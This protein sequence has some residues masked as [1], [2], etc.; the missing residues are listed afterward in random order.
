MVY[1]HQRDGT[2]INKVVFIVGHVVENAA[3]GPDITLAIVP[4]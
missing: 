2:Y 4:R 3:D 1:I